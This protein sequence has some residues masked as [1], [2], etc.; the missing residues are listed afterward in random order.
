MDQ[1]R[2]TAPILKVFSA[3]WDSR[4]D[5]L[6]GA[7]ISRATGLKSGTLYPVLV[8]LE[9]A[10]WLASRWEA[11]D[12]KALGRPRRRFYWLTALGVAKAAAAFSEF[13]PGTRREAWA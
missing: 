12:P 1:P 6:S 8:R 2:I 7:E 13:T 5:D 3:L 9:Q 11:D 4:P 10:G